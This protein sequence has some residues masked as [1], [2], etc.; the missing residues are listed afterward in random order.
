[1]PGWA[2]GALVYAAVLGC[3]LAVFGPRTPTFYW[4]DAVAT[5]LMAV[6]LTA[7]WLRRRRTRR[8][9]AHILEGPWWSALL[10]SAILSAM[11]RTGE[12]G[13]LSA[14]VGLPPWFI[15]LKLVP[16]LAFLVVLIRIVRLAR[17]PIR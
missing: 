3:A 7:V 17:A 6:L 5:G 4:I 11:Y 8:T 2:V 13:M 15:A 14:G 12:A 10:V 9:T 1:L 16:A